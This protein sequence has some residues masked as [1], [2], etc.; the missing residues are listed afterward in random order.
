MLFVTS[1]SKE[2]INPASST[3]VSEN[4]IADRS[5]EVIINAT[6]NPQGTDLANG[7]IVFTDFDS[8]PTGLDI[9]SVQ[10]LEFTDASGNPVSVQ[11]DV[12]SFEIIIDDMIFEFVAPGTN[13]GELEI[14]LEQSLIFEE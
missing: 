8:D 3:V 11:V 13:F 5:S 14:A 6:V 7:I 10:T 9:A 1:C 12:V 4:V 2:Q